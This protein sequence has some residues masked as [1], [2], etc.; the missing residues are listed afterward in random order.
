[1][2]FRYLDMIMEVLSIP[3]IWYSH[4][5]VPHIPIQ[6]K[7][8]TASQ[9]LARSIGC[10]RDEQMMQLLVSF[11]LKSDR[12]SQNSKFN[13]FPTFAA[14]QM[15]HCFCFVERTMFLQK[16]GVK[17]QIRHT[18]HK[19]AGDSVRHKSLSVD[20]ILDNNKLWN[21]FVVILIT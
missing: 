13:H 8:K 11:S 1:M 6:C 19:K 4:H 3:M 9:K 5:G 18:V 12:R 2:I 16:M 14:I 17:I 20:K 10:Q 7:N 21:N 15:S